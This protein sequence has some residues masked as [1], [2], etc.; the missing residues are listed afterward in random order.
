MKRQNIHALYVSQAGGEFHHPVDLL[1]VVS[2]ARND[3]K[4]DPNWMFPRGAEG[5]AY[6]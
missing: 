6:W 3:N 1:H 2:P 5:S 4:A